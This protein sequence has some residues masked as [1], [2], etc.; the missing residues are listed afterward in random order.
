MTIKNAQIPQS[1]T[2]SLPRQ[3]VSHSLIV[4]EAP[5]SEQDSVLAQEI[6]SNEELAGNSPEINAESESESQVE[7]VF[8][9]SIHL[10]SQQVSEQKL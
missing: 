5:I 1:F 7:S 3:G 2:V 8:E 10:G 4:D 9:M 6:A